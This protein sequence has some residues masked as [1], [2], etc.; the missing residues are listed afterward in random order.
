MPETALA[1]VPAPDWTKASIP[2]STTLPPE[3]VAVVPCSVTP[4]LIRVGPVQLL[5]ML[6][7]M[8]LLPVTPSK[9]TYWFGSIA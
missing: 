8:N 9:V 6:V 5:A 4:A 7:R 2:V 3:I 1:K